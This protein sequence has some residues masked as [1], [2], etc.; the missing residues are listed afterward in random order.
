MFNQFRFTFL[1]SKTRNNIRIAFFFQSTLN[2][3][4]SFSGTVKRNTERTARNQGLLERVK[5]LCQG[6]QPELGA[7]E[8]L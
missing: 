4:S 6:M 1:T 7:S 5:D 8:L 2:L 3:T